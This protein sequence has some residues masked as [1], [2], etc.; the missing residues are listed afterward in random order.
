MGHGL[1]P[2]KTRQDGRLDLA[3]ILQISRVKGTAWA[4]G[5]AGSLNGRLSAPGVFE[6]VWGAENQTRALEFFCVEMG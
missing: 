1:A 2:S 5:W 4:P 6:L 3:S